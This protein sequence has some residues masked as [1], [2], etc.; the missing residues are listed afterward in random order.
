MMKNLH[1]LFS[2]ELSKMTYWGFGWD[3]EGPS[4]LRVVFLGALFGATYLNP[5]YRWPEDY[6]ERDSPFVE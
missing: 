4:L 6:L 5:D 1:F 2:S 3:T